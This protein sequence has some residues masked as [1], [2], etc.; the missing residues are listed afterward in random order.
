MVKRIFAAAAFFFLAVSVFA[1]E[2]TYEIKLHRPSEVGGKHRL[3]VHGKREESQVTRTEA[4]TIGERKRAVS[5][6]LVS[7]VTV[8]EV[9][10]VGKSRRE[11]HKIVKFTKTEGDT[12]RSLLD[13]GTEVVAT[14]SGIRA[15]FTV[16]GAPA[17]A[18][19]AEALRLV[20]SCAEDETTDDDVF[21]TKEA[22]KVGQSWPVNSAV[23]A[24][25]LTNNIGVAIAP[26]DVSGQMTLKGISEHSGVKCFDISGEATMKVTPPLP[27]GLTVEKSEVIVRLSGV[28]PLDMRMQRVESTLEMN[29]ET[30]AKGKPSP[31]APEVTTEIRLFRSK[32]GR[33]SEL[34]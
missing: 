14:A 29:A 3:E 16:D 24:R 30:T 27:A 21:G 2:A 6:E 8:L 18:E 13:A 1:Q 10:S 15:D 19:V 23:I 12:T 22:V 7:E 31:D 11:S 32:E 20:V 33:Y 4:Q 25:E 17:S 5:V 34:K 26:E 9:N 28:F